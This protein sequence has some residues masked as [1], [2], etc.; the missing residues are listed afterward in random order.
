MG[1]T[2]A[3][4]L[5]FRASLPGAI[6]ISVLWHGLQAAGNIYVQRVVATASQLNGVFAL[7]L[8]LIALLYL[9]ASMA[10]IGVQVNVVRESEAV[11]AGAC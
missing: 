7:V 1:F 2:T 6:V 3:H 9:A 11:S 8:G 10:V 4:R 5:P